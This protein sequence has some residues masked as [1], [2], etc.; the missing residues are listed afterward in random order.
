VRSHF[1][2]LVLF[3]GFVSIVF[4][5]LMRDDTR[6]QVAFG[7]RLFG[8]FVVGAIVAGWLMLPFPW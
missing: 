5:A 7:A 2:L 4:A 1:A 6:E 8:A 3:S